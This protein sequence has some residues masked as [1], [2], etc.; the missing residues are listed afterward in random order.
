MQRIQPNVWRVFVPL[1]PWLLIAL[2]ASIILSRLGLGWV[3]WWVLAT[4][5]A[6]V[7]VFSYLVRRRK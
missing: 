2:I 5:I 1:L 4:I 6:A 3:P 7:P